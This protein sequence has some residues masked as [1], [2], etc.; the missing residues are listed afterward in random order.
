[1]GLFSSEYKTYVDTS[2]VRV[3]EDDQV[4]DITRNS[5]VEAVVKG[6]PLVETITENLI[7]DAVLHYNKAYN[8]AKRGEYVYGLPDAYILTNGRGATEVK[9]AIESETGETISIEYLEFSSLNHTHMAWE[10]LYNTLGYDRTSNEITGLSSQVGF[11]V[12]LDYIL[13]VFKLSEDAEPELGQWAQWGESSL[14]GYTPNRPENQTKDSYLKTNFRSGL[15]ETDS[16]E[17]HYV[18]E[19]SDS[20]QTDTVVIDL[21]TY[22]EQEYYQAR[23]TYL[24][25][26]S[27]LQVRHWTYRLGAGTHPDL[28]SIYNP[29]ASGTG[30]FFPF[31]VLRSEK[32]NRADISLHSSNEYLTT[33]KL[34]SYLSIDYQQL[35]DALH[36]NPDIS[37]VEQA[38]MLMGV[39][40]NSTDQIELA[41]LYLFFDELNTNTPYSEVEE[42]PYKIS[43]NRTLQAL[44]TGSN[45]V[46][47]V[48]R[49]SYAIVFQ[50]ADFRMTLSYGGITKRLK[51]GSLGPIG[52]LETVETT[53]EFS[54]SV[55]DTQE[56]SSISHK[57]ERSPGINRVYRKQVS[58]GFYEEITVIDPTIRFSIRGSNGVVG[59]AKDSRLIIP[60][61]K[62]ITDQLSLVQRSKLYPRSLHF[63]FNSYVKVKLEWYQTSV[64]KALITFVAVVFII[65]TG[66]AGA[67]ITSLAAAASAGVVALALFLLKV[68]VYQYLINSTFRILVKEAGIELSFIIAVFAVAAGVV[69]MQGALPGIGESLATVLLQTTNGLVRGITAQ[70]QDDYED[71][72]ADVERFELLKEDKLDDLSAANALLK[73]DVS[74]SP[75]VVFGERPEDYFNRTIH[76]SNPGLQG[77]KFVESFV[78]AS[79]TLPDI[80][81]S[82]GG[83]HV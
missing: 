3:I 15:N 35:S 64:F 8:Y 6:E 56:I 21:S 42:N 81:D 29:A 10:H 55:Y 63:V 76:S 66:G 20:I 82:L 4:P 5:V 1:M 78:S 73:Q 41:Y 62:T 65:Y 36:D 25:A 28:D 61:D 49:A 57:L 18:W 40:A 19:D 34:L 39:P 60:L 69:E 9:A 45:N 47:E 59:S 50:D 46:I 51:S 13:P 70:T 27:D 48:P 7:N 43:I 16:F 44:Y 74:L 77:I 32:S 71:L 53:E 2:V 72:L 58:E 75:F 24:D 52:F 38:V 37:D 26:Q 54:T 80:N 68:I 23:Y 22:P 33:Q 30:T 11:P 67:F 14:S 83:I 79:L 12:Y 17:I 31:V